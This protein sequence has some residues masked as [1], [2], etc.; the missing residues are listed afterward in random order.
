VRTIVESIVD[1]LGSD[2]TL[3]VLDACG[4][5]TVASWAAVHRRARRIAAW[6]ASAGFG[7][8]CRV[9]LLGDTSA[10][11]VTAIQGVWL[12]GGVI[13]V[14]PPPMREAAPAYLANLVGMNADAGLDLKVVDV[15]A[16]H[17]LNTA[18]RVV[19]LTQ[20][21]DESDNTAPM[22]VVAPDPADLAVLQYTSGSTRSPRGVPVT[23][24]NLAANLTAMR[25][26]TSDEPA[27]RERMLSWLPLYHDMGLI[28]FLALPMSLGWTLVLQSPAGFA[29]RPASW[30]ES[31]TRYRPTASGAPN[32]A[33]SLMTRLLTAGVRADLGS[34]RFLLSGGEPVNAA[35][36]AEFTEA[37]RP[38]HLD[39]S[40][41]VP[42]YGLAEAMLAVCFFPPGEGM[43]VDTIDRAL[44]ETQGRA[45][46]GLPGHSTRHLVRLGP[47]VPGTSLRIVDERTGLPAPDR[48]VGHIEVR[49]PSVV[50]H[51]QGQP[52]PRP[53][54]WFRTGD[55][56]YLVDG[57]LVVC[58]RAKDVL[59]AAGRNVFPQDV[60][61][62]A[63]DLPAVRRGAVAAFGIAGARGD[64]VVVAVESET[65]DPEARQR[66]VD[67]IGRGQVQFEPAEGAQLSR[68]GAM[69]LRQSRPAGPPSGSVTATSWSPGQSRTVRT[70][71]GQP[72]M[73][74]TQCRAPNTRKGESMFKLLK[75][76]AATALLVVSF[77]VATAATPAAAELPVGTAAAAALPRGCGYW[78]NTS[79]TA[80]KLCIELYASGPYINAKGTEASI[81]Q[82]YV[83]FFIEECDGNRQHCSVRATWF[84]DGYPNHRLDVRAF[85]GHVYHTCGSYQDGIWEFIAVCS[86]WVELPT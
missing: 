26:A 80:F 48:R 51:Y 38:C 40:A 21:V 72:R 2:G 57:E 9:G 47:P 84:G 16:A 82:A 60:E 50:G 78:P 17:A 59:F 11:L 24:A 27:R 86:P 43:R 55:L 44:L 39:P 28:G 8:G 41:I 15:P 30:L 22:P 85:K 4:E 68:A 56:G 20:L 45:E 6:L 77:L 58:G 66:D 54:S 33:H 7:R 42:A 5:P 65:T 25:Q 69:F 10:D 79:F 71:P 32:F 70:P 14:L 83:T 73:G 64:R 52:P 19:S 49:G 36:L 62:A 23:H 34:L 67:T 75:R 1:S 29:R 63:A 81:R 18:A 61:S 3:T 76:L 74:W 31:V 46:L 12:A 35:A 37:A 13:S 53:G